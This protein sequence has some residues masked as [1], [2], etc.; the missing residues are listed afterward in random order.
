M[1]DTTLKSIHTVKYGSVLL[2]P[3]QNSEVYNIIS[4]LLGK[5]IQDQ[6]ISISGETVI[7]QEILLN[8]TYT[9]AQTAQG[10]HIIKRSLREFQ[11]LVILRHKDMKNVPKDKFMEVAHKN[12][13]VPYDYQSLFKNT[14]THI[15]NNVPLLDNLI[16][17]FVN[18]TIPYFNAHMMICSEVVQKIHYD[19]GLKL[20]DDDRPQ[21]HISPADFLRS[22]YMELIYKPKEFTL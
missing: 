4:N 10:V 3:S 5:M 22:P 13:N 8:G 20:F 2:F 14:L 19:L 6:I 7:H 1:S 12:W 15:L 16:E 18:K 9:L 21:E 11:N 17:Q